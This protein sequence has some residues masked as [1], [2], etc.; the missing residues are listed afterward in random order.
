MIGELLDGRFG[1]CNLTPEL[2]AIGG[3]TLVVHLAGRRKILMEAPQL[4][5]TPNKLTKLGVAF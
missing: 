2:V 3:I 5:S 4:T 1:R